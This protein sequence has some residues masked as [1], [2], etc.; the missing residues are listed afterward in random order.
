MITGSFA[1]FF[2]L[3][4]ILSM[5]VWAYLAYQWVY[6]PEKVR[7]TAFQRMSILAQAL[8]LAKD[9]GADLLR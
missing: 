7:G 6:H 1:P 8:E 5:F 4:G 3:L 9:H 2:E